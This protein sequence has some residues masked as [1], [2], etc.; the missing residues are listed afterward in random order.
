MP[1]VCRERTANY[2]THC[3]LEPDQGRG[4]KLRLREVKLPAW[5]CRARRVESG[6]KL[7]V[8]WA[9][10]KTPDLVVGTL[11]DVSSGVWYNPGFRVAPLG[12]DLGWA[13]KFQT[14]VEQ[15]GPSGVGLGMLQ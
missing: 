5:G 3:S 15:K 1:A 4:S 14:Q 2:Y 11:G 6:F 12:Q 10:V 13:G 8:P 9:K 7:R